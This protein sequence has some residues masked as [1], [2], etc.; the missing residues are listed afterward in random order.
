MAE[1]TL[2]D[3][4]NFFSVP[5]KP[6]TMAELKELDSNDRAELK[7]LVTEHMNS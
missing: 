2:K 6:V 4:Q 5:H 7:A 1:A 3:I